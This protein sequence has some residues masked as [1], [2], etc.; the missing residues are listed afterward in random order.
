VSA[1]PASQ[2]RGVLLAL[3]MAAV[4]VSAC[5]GTDAA[6]SSALPTVSP[7]GRPT[8]TVTVFA[9]ASLTETLT[10]LARQVEADNPGLEVVLSFGASSTL[11]QQVQAGAPADVLATASTKTM[12]PVVEAGLAASTPRVFARNRL[13][14]ATPRGNP[15]RVESLA[16]LARPQLT[17]A[18]CA[19]QVPCGAAAD[20]AL[21]AAGVT[22]APDTL[23]RDVKA[24]LAKVR[25]GEV[26]AGLVYR[27]DVT[28]AGDAVTGVPFPQA[29]QAVTDYPVVALEAAPNPRAAAAFV[30]ALLGPTGRRALA[31][32]GF[33]AP[34]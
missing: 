16:D 8:G 3:S 20:K 5:G 14:I 11:A 34:P 2:R 12:Q 6:G 10:A 21:A 1:A 27:T 30:D 29:D 23:E 25:L 32:A 24:V 33:E 17:I 15:A 28:A 7:S 4:L 19:P 18:L 9:A 26:D 22:P 13:E 31:S